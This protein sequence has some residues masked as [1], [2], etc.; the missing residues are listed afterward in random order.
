M[1]RRIL[2]AVD[3]SETSTLAL[4][5]ALQLGKDQRAHVRIVHALESLQYLVALAGGYVFDIGELLDS[6]RREGER[7]LAESADR[8]RAAGVEAEAALIEGK[9]PMD[10]TA[11]IVVEDARR[12]DADLIVLGTHG[13]RG[14]DRLFLGSVAEHVLRAASVPVLLVRAR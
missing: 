10:R 14:F 4:E 12:W 3:G 13:R 8:A 7:V 2:V 5:H 11:Q 1:Y 9:E 6:L